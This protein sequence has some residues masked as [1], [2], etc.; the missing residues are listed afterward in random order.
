MGYKQIDGNKTILV[1]ERGEVRENLRNLPPDSDRFI[2]EVDKKGKRKN[3]WPKLIISYDTDGREDVRLL[4]EVVLKTHGKLPNQLECSADDFKAVD[5]NKLNCAEENVEY[6]GDGSFSKGS[7]YKSK[8]SEKKA[9][10]PEPEAEPEPE[11]EDPE[12]EENPEAEEELSDLAKGSA[13]LKATEAVNVI[14]KYDFQELKD[15]GFYT[16]DA[17]NPRVTVAEAW[18]KA[19]KDYREANAE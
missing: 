12:V 3:V 8:D 2:F 14:K 1:N 6:V 7:P 4:P 10:K 16:E 19:E 13:D 9:Q 17:D 15:S 11:P 5:G 18:K